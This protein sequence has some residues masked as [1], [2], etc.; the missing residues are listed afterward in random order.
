MHPSVVACTEIKYP[1][2]SGEMTYFALMLQ[3]PLVVILVT[4]LASKLLCCEDSLLI[5]LA[6]QLCSC[7]PFMP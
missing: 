3:Q 5:L 7:F 4:G 1:Q 2:L 6:K